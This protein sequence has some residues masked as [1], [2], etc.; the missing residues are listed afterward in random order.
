MEQQ[1]RAKEVA[2]ERERC[3]AIDSWRFHL[4]GTIIHN[5]TRL[6]GAVIAASI[7]GAAIILARASTDHVLGFCAGLNILVGIFGLTLFTG[8]MRIRSLIETA[9]EFMVLIPVATVGDVQQ[10]QQDNNE[11]DDKSKKE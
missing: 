7:L 3:K 9:H 5:Q 11:D 6:G 1:Q 4:L 8:S 10:K 2:P